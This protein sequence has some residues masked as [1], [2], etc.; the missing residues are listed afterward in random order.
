M[1]ADLE[2]FSKGRGPRTYFRTTP[3]IDN[4]DRKSFVWSGG[5]GGGGGSEAFFLK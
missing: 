3:Y 1:R 5:G 4:D 2:Q